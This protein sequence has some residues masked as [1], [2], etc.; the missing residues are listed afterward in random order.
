RK[1]EVEVLEG[2]EYCGIYSPH[3]QAE[4]SYF[5]SVPGGFKIIAHSNPDSIINVL[6]RIGNE[7]EGIAMSVNPGSKIREGINAKI[8]KSVEDIDPAEPDFKNQYGFCRIA[9]RPKNCNDILECG[10]KPKYEVKEDLRKQSITYGKETIS[11]T[12]LLANYADAE[13]I[14]KPM[15]FRNVKPNTNKTKLHPIICKESKDKFSIKLIDPETQVETPLPVDMLWGIDDSKYTSANLRFTNFAAFSS[16]VN[17]LNDSISSDIAKKGF[18]QYCLCGKRDYPTQS[19]KTDGSYNFTADGVYFDE[20][21]EAHEMT[22]KDDYIY[23][24]NQNKD[25]SFVRKIKEL[26]DSLTCEKIMDENYVRKIQQETLKILNN[27]I[28]KSIFDWSKE[29]GYEYS[30]KVYGYTPPDPVKQLNREI[31]INKVKDGKVWKTVNKYLAE[32]KYNVTK[33]DGTIGPAEIEECPIC[34]P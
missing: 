21:L 7:V 10:S 12:N 30:S 18:F 33:Q 2:G 5:S 8:E 19:F 31:E 6:I 4:S 17:G 15:E 11:V 32:L 13:G 3:Y 27:Y 23:F 25:S 34:Y 22:H 24:I 14:F 1:Y 29:Y 26:N 16:A 20:I 9:V 28:D